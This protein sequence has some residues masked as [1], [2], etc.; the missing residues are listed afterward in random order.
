MEPFLKS[1]AQWLYAKYGQSFADI[2]LVFPNRRSGV[3][4]LEHL[5]TMIDKPIWLPKNQTISEFVG[6]FSSLTQADSLELLSVLYQ[7]FKKES[8]SAETFDEFYFWGELML[9]DFNDI[10]KYLVDAQIVLQNVKSI[11]EIED[12]HSF[13]SE[14]Q[15]E[16]IKR[17][18]K[19][20]DQNQKTELKKE[21]LKVWSILLPVYNSFTQHLIRNKIGYEGLIYKQAVDFLENRKDDLTFKKV[22]FVGFNALTPCEERIFT[23]LKNQ[24]LAEFAWDY[25]NY[26]IKNPLMEAGM[27]QRKLIQNYPNTYIQNF[28]N[29]LQKDK[30][31]NLIPVPTDHG[32]VLSVAQLIETQKQDNYSNTALVLSDEQL[33]MPVLN[34]V[35]AQVKDLNVTMGYPVKDSLAGNLINLL[36]SL[37]QTKKVSDDGSVSFFYKPLLQLLRHPFFQA[38]ASVSCNALIADIEKENLYFLNTSELKSDELFEKVFVNV[39]NPGE[40]GD[41]LSNLV[42]FIQQELE[43]QEPENAVF[44]L[45][46][47]FLNEIRLKNNQLTYQLTSF[48]LDLKLP[49]FYRLLQ[50]VIQ[51]IRAPFEGEPINGLQIMGFLETRNLDFE[52]V[53]ILSVNEGMLPTSGQSPSFIPYSLRRGFGLPT[54][55]LHDAMYAYYFYRIIQRAKQVTLLYNSG[56]GGMQTGEK[57]RFAYQLIYDS[58]FKVNEMAISQAIEVVSDQEIVVQKEGAVKEKLKAYLESERSLSPSALS[59]YLECSL[60]FYFKN[61]LKIKE[62]DEVEEK[63]DARLFGNIFHKAAEK[64]YQPYFDKKELITLH[65]LE[66]LENDNI[67]LHRIIKE[68]FKEVFLGEKS[69]RQFAING[70]NAIVFD[71]IKKYLVQLIQIDKKVSPFSIVGLEYDFRQKITIDVNGEKRWVYVGGQIDRLDRNDSGIRV[72]DYKTG[73]D[74]LDFKEFDDIFNHET[75]KDTKAIFQTFLY[76]FLVGQHFNDQS[77]FPMVYQVRNLF[78]EK[79]SFKI[80]SKNCDVFQNGNF[81]PLEKEVHEKLKGILQELF[82]EQIPFVQT[83][84]KKSC[85][86]CTYKLFCGR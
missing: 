14:E 76:S 52:H 15:L 53:Y 56:S 18:F 46:R 23:L 51:S 54:K 36:V 74:K 59:T 83:A 55:E 43:Q 44:E 67:T 24:G 66:K 72:I 77:I 68:S 12:D 41:Y 11:K 85:E 5:K 61:L 3:F 70:K 13:L 49:T 73:G 78:D 17:F 7:I 33:L 20:F 6:D 40:F 57:S 37:Q 45:E 27:F 79:T 42:E 71:V 16:V 63:V 82:D 84:N 75:I 38:V 48:N 65:E 60:R 25:D 1:V 30:T 58:N 39:L 31:I 19:N 80:S 9:N 81:K 34:A 69:K 4:L 47:Q 29:L 32:Q 62:P 64:L 26:Y 10:D 22:I 28:E 21:F 35:P 50:K 8:K 86:Y 2:R